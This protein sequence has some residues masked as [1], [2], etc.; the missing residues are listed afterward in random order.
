[1][2]T[3]KQSLKSLVGSEDSNFRRLIQSQKSWPLNELPMAGRV[4][5]EPTC[6]R[7]KGS[8]LI[9]SAISLQNRGDSS[10]TILLRSNAS[11]PL[12]HGGKDWGDVR[13]LDAPE[14]G[15]SRSPNRS[16]NAAIKTGAAVTNRP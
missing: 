4:G 6:T 8:C 16:D 13:E 7:S 3:Q 12:S 10:R 14:P 9:R 1:M 11:L 5:I 2:G 15:H